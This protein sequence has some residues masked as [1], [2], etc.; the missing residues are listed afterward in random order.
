MSVPAWLAAIMQA[1]PSIGILQGLVTGATSASAFARIFQ[2]G[3]RHGMRSYTIGHA[4][5]NGDCGPYWGHN[6]VA[7]V[8]PFLEACELPVLPGKPPLGGCVLSH[9]QI[10]A[11]LMR[12][13]GFEV[14]VLP[15]E[16]ES[17]EDNPPTLLD[18]TK[19]DLRW[20][21]GNMQYWRLIGLAG[22]LPLSRCQIM[23]AILMYLGSFAWTLMIVFSA[24]KV[25]EPPMGEAQTGLG[26]ALF[27]VS[28]VMSIAPK[29]AGMLD[30]ALTPGGLSR[31]G[32][33]PR[34]LAG[35]ITEIVFSMLLAPIAAIRITIFMISLMF[36][37]SVIWSG[38]Q[39]DTDGL[40]WVTACQGLWPQTLCGLALTVL[41]AWKAPGALVWAAPLLAGLTFAIPFA[42]IT[43]SPGFGLP[44]RVKLRHPRG[45]DTPPESG[46]RPAG[47]RTMRPPPKPLK[48]SRWRRV[49]RPDHTLQR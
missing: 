48:N 49:E 47:P 36:G 46:S 25:F 15:V 30:V 28:F 19:R 35:V 13:A 16:G 31:Y 17:W 7:R 45:T 5:W 23:L 32:G 43:A 9:D 39:R 38:Q 42:V 29:L 44:A 20:C 34:F 1:R 4:W 14:R 8:A 33:A 18:F 10:E 21:Q 22:L 24:L 2:F 6:A 27:A 37:R 11:A 40:S 12:R 3:M 41:L 26:I